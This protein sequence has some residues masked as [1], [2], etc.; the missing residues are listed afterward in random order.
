MNTGRYGRICIP[1]NDRYCLSCDKCDNED[2]LT[3]FVL[4]LTIKHV[5]K[6]NVYIH[7]FKNVAIKHLLVSN[8]TVLEVL[9]D[10][11]NLYGFAMF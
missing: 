7:V 11:H 2:N 6:Y 5:Q 4:L 9:T 10:N 3:L 8:S 1:R